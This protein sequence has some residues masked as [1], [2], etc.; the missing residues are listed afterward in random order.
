MVQI[1]IS[2][3]WNI[4]FQDSSRGFYQVTQGSHCACIAKKPKVNS[5]NPPFQTQGN[6]EM[7]VFGDVPSA[8]HDSWQ[9]GHHKHHVEAHMPGKEATLP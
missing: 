7:S 1:M 8:M 2:L 5:P 9:V 3:C 4:A 6:V